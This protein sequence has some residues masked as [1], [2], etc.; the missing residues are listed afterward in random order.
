MGATA[1][2]KADRDTRLVDEF[3]DELTVAIAL[4]NWDHAVMLV[5]EGERTVGQAGARGPYARTPARRAEIV[6]AAR[7]SFAER[8]YAN[9]SL[10]DIAERLAARRIAI[11]VD[12]G[13]RDW[14]AA[15]GY[16]DVYGARAIA[17]VVRTE[18][19]FPLAQ[20]M[21]RGTIR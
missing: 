21:L 8:G 7:D 5:E 18:V 15:Q 13:A 10:R 16:S 17:R 2:E 12:P 1:K 9:A 6:R 4:R 14:L 20:K 19:L 11:D 3:S